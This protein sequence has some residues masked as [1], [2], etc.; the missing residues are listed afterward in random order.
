[1]LQLIHNHMI[2]GQLQT[3]CSHNYKDRI[4]HR[5]NI[6][7]H[8]CRTHWGD[9]I[10]NRWYKVN[11]MHIICGT[12]RFTGWGR[13]QTVLRELLG[14]SHGREEV[15]R[16]VRLE[17]KGYPSPKEPMD[18]TDGR[19][20][21]FALA[22][23]SAIIAEPYTADGTRLDSAWTPLV[24]PVRWHQTLLLSIPKLQQVLH[25]VRLAERGVRVDR[26]CHAKKIYDTTRLKASHQLGGSTVS[27]PSDGNHFLLR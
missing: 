23:E 21:R 1:M 2:S 3:C 4:R 6:S 7:I 13:V 24:L 20:S 16:E 19:R 5:L 18:C 9:P 17:E 15:T 11:G 26:G 8:R 22:V 10:Q 25:D 27:L 14:T 12:F